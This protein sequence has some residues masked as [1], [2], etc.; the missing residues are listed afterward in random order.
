MTQPEIKKLHI[1]EDEFSFW[2]SRQLAKLHA[3]HMTEAF[4]N[5]AYEPRCLTG[6]TEEWYIRVQDVR[7]EGIDAEGRTIGRQALQYIEDLAH[8]RLLAA[9]Y[10]R[11]ELFS[12][13]CATWYMLDPLAVVEDGVP[14][15]EYATWA[16]M[17]TQLVKQHASEEDIAAAIKRRYHDGAGKELNDEQAASLTE[18]FKPV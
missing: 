8:S 10:Q 17:T 13:H 6:H 15:D 12:Q 11:D 5:L 3:Q 9:D 1:G 16:A 18:L 2:T 4:R 7:G 14:A